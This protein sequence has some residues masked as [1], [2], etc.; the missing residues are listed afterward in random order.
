[1]PDGP[2]ADDH[3]RPAME[4]NRRTVTNWWTPLRPFATH[5]NSTQEHN[6]DEKQI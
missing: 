4:N 2:K 1:V 3:S 6:G 5:E